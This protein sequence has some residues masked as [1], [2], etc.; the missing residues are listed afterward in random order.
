[1]SAWL[2]LERAEG[3]WGLGFRVEEEPEDGRTVQKRPSI[4]ARS[5]ILISDKSHASL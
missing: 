1:M 2:L 5:L 3:E 4:W